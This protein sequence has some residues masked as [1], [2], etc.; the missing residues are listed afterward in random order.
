VWD[1]SRFYR[2]KH[3]AT[4]VKADLRA[5]GVFV[6]PVTHP[7]DPSTVGGLWQESI[8]ETQAQAYSMDVRE[9]TLKSMPYVFSQ[10]HNDPQHSELNWCYKGGGL[11]PFGY[12]PHHVDM[13]RDRKGR[14]KRRLL[15]LLL[16]FEKE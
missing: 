9:K 7:Y 4:S 13:G 10:R 12:Q 16:E 2:N 14:Q 6:V 15:W 11:P 1:E 8:Y 3:R 5:Q